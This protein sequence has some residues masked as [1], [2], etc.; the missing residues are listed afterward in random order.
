MARKNTINFLQIENGLLK[1]IATC[2]E[3]ADAPYAT[4]RPQ[5]EEASE[6]LTGV[7]ASTD[8]SYASWR[9]TIRLRLIGSKHLLARFEQI[10]EELGEYG[11]EPQPSGRVDYWDSE[12]QLEAVQTLLGQLAVLKASDVPEASGWLAALKDDLKSVERLL[13]EEEQAKDDY[14][15]VAPARRQVI[16]RAMHVVEEF[17]NVRR[18]YLS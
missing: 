1:A 5:L 7:M 18:D 2:V 10:R 3:E 9:E 4:H 12:F 6:T 8:R 17:E 13:R 16:S 11:V 15:R 14:L